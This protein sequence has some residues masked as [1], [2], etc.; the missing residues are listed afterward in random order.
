LEESGKFPYSKVKKALDKY[1]GRVLL[2]IDIFSGSPAHAIVKTS[3]G[4]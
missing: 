4:V 2:L 3:S 1:G